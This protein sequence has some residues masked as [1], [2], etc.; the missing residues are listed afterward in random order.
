M[1]AASRSDV[2]ASVCLDSWTLSEAAATAAA[3]AAATCDTSGGAG[4]L[5]QHFLL[6]PVVG[7]ALGALVVVAAV[8][9]RFALRSGQERLLEIAAAAAIGLGGW[10]VVAALTRV[11]GFAVLLGFA[12]VGAGAVAIAMRV[13]VRVEAEGLIDVLHLPRKPLLEDTLLASLQ[14]DN[15]SKTLGYL[16][17]RFFFVFVWFPRI[18][19]S[20]FYLSANTCSA[21]CCLARAVRRCVSPS[22]CVCFV[23]F[24]VAVSSFFPLQSKPICRSS[25]WASTTWS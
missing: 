21:L 7:A 14:E 8:M 3:A 12:L 6:T 4:E 9:A 22:K 17:E 23:V 1:A 15:F 11:F 5:L 2:T 10:V 20:A 24:L 18:L 19:F 25:S 16:G 13:A